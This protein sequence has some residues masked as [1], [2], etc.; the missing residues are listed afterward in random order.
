MYRGYHGGLQSFMSLIRWNSWNTHS[1]HI[2]KNQ[3]LRYT[4]LHPRNT[5][6]INNK[7]IEKD[8]QFF[9]H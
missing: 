7:L 1:F 2:K 8:K 5:N 3:N 9:R 4:H 6:C